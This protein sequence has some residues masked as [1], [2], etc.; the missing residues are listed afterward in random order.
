MKTLVKPQRAQKRQRGKWATLLW[1]VPMSLLVLAGLVLLAKWLR[2]LPD[3][4]SFMMQFPGHSQL[5]ES[6][7]VGFQSWLSWQ[8]FMN[9]LF[10]LLII[11]SGIQVRT[12]AR[13]AS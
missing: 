7:P 10:I 12:V 11:R 13:S 6:A 2:T 4:Q 8:H 5:P 1:A 3:V 9:S